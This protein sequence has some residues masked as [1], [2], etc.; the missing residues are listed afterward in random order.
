[1]ASYLTCGN[2]MIPLSASHRFPPSAKRPSPKDH[3]AER[4]KRRRRN[5]NRSL[6]LSLSLFLSILAERGSR[7]SRRRKRQEILSDFPRTT[8]CR[9]RLEKDKKGNKGRHFAPSFQIDD[10]A[11]ENRNVARAHEDLACSVV[12]RIPIGADGRGRPVRRK[13]GLGKSIG[14]AR[15][16]ARVCG[17]TSGLSCSIHLSKSG[18][19]IYIAPTDSLPHSS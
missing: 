14:L 9:N 11:S 6:S 16:F 10:G 3:S 1:M 18:A 19:A 2:F 4:Q 8:G 7:P 12:L 15:P 5:T 13:K 17:T